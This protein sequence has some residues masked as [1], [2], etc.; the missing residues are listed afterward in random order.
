MYSKK[1]TKKS[2]SSSPSAKKSSPSTSA[3][4]AEK[5]EKITPDQG[6]TRGPHPPSPSGE[7]ILQLVSHLPRE[8]FLAKNPTGYVFLDLDDDWIFSVQEE[9]EKFGYEV[10]P[11]FAGPEAVGAHVTVVPANNAKNYKGMVEVGKKVEFEVVRASTTFPIRYWYGTEA[12]FKIWVKSPELSRISKEISGSGYN[13]PSGF[14][15]VVGIRTI[16]KRDQMMQEI[17]SKKKYKKS[18]K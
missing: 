18:K 9:M 13:P 16:K 8:G 11:Y 3:G 15:I 1:S 10:P 4:T 6:R 7:D 17:E 5:R 12:V 2:S 14:N